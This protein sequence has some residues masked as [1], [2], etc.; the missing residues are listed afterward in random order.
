M[1][2]TEIPL[3][4]SLNHYRSLDIWMQSRAQTRKG[5]NAPEYSIQSR[6]YS[7]PS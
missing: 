7:Y 1:D 5:Y 6:A 3:R 2:V 4:I